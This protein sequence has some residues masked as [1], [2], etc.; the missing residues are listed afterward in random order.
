M[1]QSLFY[2]LNFTELFTI[3]THSV[4][5]LLFTILGSLMIGVISSFIVWWFLNHLLVPNIIFPSIISKVKLKDSVGY[6]YRIGFWN[7]GFRDV[8]DAEIIFELTAKALDKEIQTNTS[9]IRFNMNKPNIPIIKKKKDR[10]SLKIDTQNLPTQLDDYKDNFVLEKFLEEKN[11]KVHVIIF[12]Y[13]RYSGSR[14]VFE[15]KRYTHKDIKEDIFHKKYY[16]RKYLI[17]YLIWRVPKYT[18]W[19]LLRK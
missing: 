19:S 1:E 3:N 7:I 11:A 8:I 18:K 14:K 12:G 10:W 16:S 2:S 4:S 6:K 13:D 15:S 9:H 5:N 17:D